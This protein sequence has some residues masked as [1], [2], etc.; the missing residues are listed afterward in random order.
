MLVCIGKD[1]DSLF[2]DFDDCVNWYG[3][4]SGPCIRVCL[5]VIAMKRET[6]IWELHPT[7]SKVTPACMCTLC[8]HHV[9]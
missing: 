4:L 2:R 3:A 1:W 6:A 5:E 8:C 9:V 7:M